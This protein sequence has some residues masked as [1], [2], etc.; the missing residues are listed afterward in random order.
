MSYKALYRTYRP[1]TFEEVAGQKV[2]VQ[3]LQ[4]ALNQNK[5]AHAYLF[6]GPRGTGKTTMA[7]LFAKALNCEKGIG[8]QCNECSNC[9]A[10]NDGS[11]QDIIEI[12]A[13]SNNGVDDIRALV[14]NVNYAPIKGRYKV[15]IIDEVHMMSAN[16]FN[17]LLK[18]LEEPP[19]HVVFIL[20]TTE[21]HKII[22]TILSRCQR[23]NFSK[24]SDKD[25]KQRMIEI[26]KIENISYEES[27]ID[28]IISLADGG[29]RDAL[30][31]LDQVLAYANQTLNEEDVL[32]LFALLN[33]TDKLDLL[34][35]IKDHNVKLL[36]NKIS[37]FL[38]KG[39][40]VRRLS[41]DLLGLLKDLL[42]FYKTKDESLM[43]FL[44]K[45]EAKHL[46]A[47]L[48][49]SRLNELINSL[50]KALNDFRFVTDLRSLFELTLL[51]MAS[52]GDDFTSTKIEQPVNPTSLETSSK[53]EP[54]SSVEQ[55][56]Q[57]NIKPTIVKKVE[58]EKE[59][60]LPPF[61]Q[62]QESPTQKTENDNKDQ[63]RETIPFPIS[64]NEPPPLEGPELMFAREEYLPIQEEHKRKVA[65]KRKV[66]LDALVIET[67]KIKV[68]RFIKEGP[69]ISLSDDTL[70]KAMTL[71][72]RDE[73]RNLY[74]NAWKKLPF[75]GEEDENL[76][77]FSS[78]LHNGTPYI[79]T[80]QLLV[81]VYEF[82]EH[83]NLCNLIDNQQSL[84]KIIAEFLGREVVVYA[85]SRTHER[86]VTKLFTNLN[87]LHQLPRVK[88]IDKELE[89]I[90]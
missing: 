7:K 24:V 50:L 49:L 26:L 32:D 80:D 39:I 9:L 56:I 72:S 58:L 5:I 69:S 77:S 83:A 11:H 89:E 66:I 88:N 23:Y 63:N 27:A 2:I 21:P 79:L 28:L 25:I 67:P 85:I 57:E 14:D 42:I 86:K 4:N 54:I 76:A 30:S 53:I 65:Q 40:D 37:H 10:V 75:M 87:Q 33:K 41:A 12:D 29:V 73:R 78:L 70:I 31:M 1:S 22:P 16:A 13:A 60:E 36:M 52:S 74:D 64:A 62:E 51:Q 8:H 46:S 19:S 84:R 55:K 45:R 38:D 3:T 68:G 48:S 43:L 17:A 61:L 35:A 71:G 44:T 15:Y 82:N 34:Y 20:A 81:L 90:L 6:A 47:N 59:E 18:T